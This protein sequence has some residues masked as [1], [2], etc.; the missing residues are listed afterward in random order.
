MLRSTSKPMSSR[1]P[2]LPQLRPVVQPLL[3][4]ALEAALG[5]VVELLAAERFR[6]V[7]LA[8]EGVRRVMVVVVACAVA[9]RFHQA[10]WGIEDVLGRQERAALLSRLHGGA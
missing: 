6:E 8:G 1:I 10:G 2:L 3:D 4:L 5:R 9:L 7:I